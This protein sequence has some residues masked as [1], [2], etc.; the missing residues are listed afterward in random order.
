MRPIIKKILALWLII[1]LTL[2]PPLAYAVSAGGW[3][4]SKYDIMLELVTAMRGGVSSTVKFTPPTPNMVTVLK[5]ASAV[6]IAYAIAKYGGQA[7]DWVM[8]PANNTVR[9]KDG[10]V[11]TGSHLNKIYQGFSGEDVC[12]K[13]TTDVVASLSKV[14]ITGT[15]YLRYA[16][17]R[18]E[19]GRDNTAFD[20][21]SVSC[22]AGN[23]SVPISDLVPDVI[24]DAKKGNPTAQDVVNQAVQ[25]A[26][27][28]G[29]TDNALANAKTDT[30][31]THSC[32][33]GTAWNGS[34]CV[35]DKVDIPA[36]DPSSILN[37]I[38]SLADILSAVLQNILNEIKA[39]ALAIVEPIVKVINNAWDWL[40]EKYQWWVEQ[41]T[42]FTTGVKEFFQWVRGEPDKT[43]DTK[44]NI[45]TAPSTKSAQDFDSNYINFGG[46]CPS[47]SPTTISVGIYT[48]NVSFNPQP[49]CDFAILCR[50]VILA[51]AYF[52]AM[53]IV[54]NAIRSE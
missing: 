53:A 49:L 50:P 47:F 45:D 14:G 54:A 13:A 15:S 51:L 25:D 4:F 18:C 43:D 2:A 17:N 9:K 44:P 40:K 48:S 38:K 39:L 52:G 32:G 12:K 37:A 10:I 22:G 1:Y 27:N 23:L 35:A 19:Y 5:G 24:A 11:C 7:I 16:A 6:A 20:S 28:A 26:V 34:A 30:D 29:T 41:W 33:T 3:S 21:F 8:D 42:T 36:F 31:A 46:Q